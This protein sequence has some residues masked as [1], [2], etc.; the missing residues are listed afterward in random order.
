MFQQK[1][2]PG[3]HF[4]TEETPGRFIGTHNPGF[5][6]QDQVASPVRRICELF[7]AP[8]SRSDIGSSR[9]VFEVGYLIVTLY[10]VFILSSTEQV[11]AENLG[12]LTTQLFSDFLSERNDRP[13]PSFAGSKD[14]VR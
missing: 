7:S 5:S 10:I 8:F 14:L 2:F 9:L 13:K 4:L 6:I 11:E 3:H 1:G 12:A